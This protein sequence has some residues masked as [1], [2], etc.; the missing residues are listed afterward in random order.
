MAMVI[1]ASPGHSVKIA[2]V[3]F[4]LGN[5]LTASASL[6]ASLANLAQTAEATDLNLSGAQLAELGQEIEHQIEM[7]YQA[8]ETRQPYWLDVWQA[9]VTHC[10][11][12]L[13]PSD[14]ERL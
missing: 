13:S 4:D 2:A 9:A 1:P 14:T 12:N 7:L 3:L 5:T 10:H 8:T 11:L 6:A